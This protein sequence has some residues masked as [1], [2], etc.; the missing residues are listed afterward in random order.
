[1]TVQR[2]AGRRTVVQVHVG[3]PLAQRRSR[4]AGRP[5][6]AVC[7]LALALIIGVAIVVGPVLYVVLENR[8]IESITW[9]QGEQYG[10]QHDRCGGRAGRPDAVRDGGTRLD[11]RWT[12][13]AGG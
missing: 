13:L 4:T 8:I 12:A 10:P 2:S 11:G 1:M 7:L 5:R 9:I 3:R 6:D